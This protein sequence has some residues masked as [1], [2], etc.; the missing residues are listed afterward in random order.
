VLWI[1]KKKNAFDVLE[2][3]YGTIQDNLKRNNARIMLK[4]FFI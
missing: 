1:S 4:I 2:F 3:S